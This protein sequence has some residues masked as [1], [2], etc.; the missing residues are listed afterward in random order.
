MYILYS[1]NTTKTYMLYQEVHYN[2]VISGSTLLL[3]NALSVLH[4]FFH[5]HNRQAVPGTGGTVQLVDIA[6]SHFHLKV[7]TWL[8]L[9]TLHRGG[10]MQYIRNTLP[11]FSN[12]SD[13][14]YMARIM[15]LHS[16]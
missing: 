7:T 14:Y 1:S 15:Q 5:Q 3:C 11:D 12:T 10:N 13:I 16:K 4:P 8:G 6:L 2:C 9:Y